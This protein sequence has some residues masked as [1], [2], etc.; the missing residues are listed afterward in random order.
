VFRFTDIISPKEVRI[1]QIGEDAWVNIGGLGGT[2]T[3]HT[4]V[5]FK[6]M[7]LHDLH[8]SFDATGHL[9][10]THIDDHVNPPVAASDLNLLG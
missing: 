4:A 9:T 7:A 2:G 1:E 6:G 10:I 8:P 3:D 5:A